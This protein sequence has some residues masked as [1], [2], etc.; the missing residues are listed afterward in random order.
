VR[1]GFELEYIPERC[2]ASSFLFHTNTQD[3]VNTPLS[4]KRLVSRS[5]TLDLVECNSFRYKCVM[6]ASWPIN[7]HFSRT[8]V[9][10]ITCLS[11][12]RLLSCSYRSARIGAGKDVVLKPSRDLRITNAALADYLENAQQRT[13]IQLNYVA[14]KSRVV[15]K[16]VVCSLLAGKVCVN[17]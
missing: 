3:K 17:S 11:L 7:G 14:K 10:L 15:S 9:C 16:A 8:L 2:E 4:K 12:K 13:I 6:F 5:R 1:D